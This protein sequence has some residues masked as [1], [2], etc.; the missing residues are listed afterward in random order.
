MSNIMRDV[1]RTKYCIDLEQQGQDD[2][3]IS[4]N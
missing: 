3:L 4:P 1:L 2:L